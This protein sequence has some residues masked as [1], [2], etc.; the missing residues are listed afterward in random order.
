MSEV[1]LT[2]RGGWTVPFA[3]HRVDDYRK[4]ADDCRDLAAKVPE[5]VRAQLL[6]F[7]R[8]WDELAAERERYLAARGE[9]DEPDPTLSPPPVG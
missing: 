2:H 7:A 4:N 5:T 8:H 1:P 3:M 9:T 6:E